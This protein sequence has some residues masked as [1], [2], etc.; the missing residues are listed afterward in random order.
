MTTDKDKKA[1]IQAEV[2]RRVAEVNEKRRKPRRPS[3]DVPWYDR[4]AAPISRS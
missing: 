2:F 4:P 3:V 1:E